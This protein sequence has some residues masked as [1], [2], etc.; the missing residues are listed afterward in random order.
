MTDETQAATDVINEALADENEKLQRQLREM[1]S[2]LG[3]PINVNVQSPDQ[4]TLRK[5]GE[6]LPQL[7]FMA[8][9]ISM[10]ASAIQAVNA[11]AIATTKMLERI[12]VALEKEDG[13]A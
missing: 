6:Y 1:Q 12:A 3:R 8:T 5:I 10:V 11:N 2:L 13:D 9:N 4:E 7:T